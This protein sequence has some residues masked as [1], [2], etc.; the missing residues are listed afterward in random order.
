MHGT[1]L[2]CRQLPTGRDLKREFIAAML[3]MI[4]DGWRIVKISK[5]IRSFFR[6]E[7]AER[8]RIDISADKAHA[9]GR[10]R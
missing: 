5:P 2:E 6:P 8:R 7:N 9:P 4:D 1:V 3:R 10:L